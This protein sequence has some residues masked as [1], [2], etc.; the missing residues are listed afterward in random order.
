MAADRRRLK[1]D[2]LAEVICELRFDCEEANQ[3]PELVVGTLAGR[4]AWQDYQKVRL[5]VSDVPA[6]IRQADQ[7]LRY[8]PIFEL[9]G[10]GRAVKIGTNV[11]SLHVMRPYPGWS[12]FRPELMATLEFAFQRMSN[13]RSTRIGFRFINTLS[14]DQLIERITDLNFSITINNEK[15]NSPFVLFFARQREQHHIAQIRISSPEYVNGVIP[16]SFVGLVDLDVAT[17]NGFTT[18]SFSQVKDWIDVAHDIA[19]EEFFGLLNAK[20]LTNVEELA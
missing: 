18:D 20:M 1:R 15:I 2:G 13:F 17:P 3:L 10:D 7:N 9:R 14:A 5:P 16:P 11:L 8:Q 4:P 6:P 12:Q 19:K